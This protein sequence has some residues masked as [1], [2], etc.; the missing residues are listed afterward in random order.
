MKKLSVAL[1]AL[2]FVFASCS[3][4]STDSAAPNNNNNNNNNPETFPTTK[5]ALFLY[6]T[7]SECNP[8]GSIGIPNYNTII[9][10]LNYKDKVVPVS[11]HCN[12]PAPD[13]MYVTSTGGDLLQLIIVNNSYSAPTYLVPPNA[14]KS[15]VDGDAVSKIQSYI[16]TISSQPPT[17]VANVSATYAA[18]TG[19]WSVKTRTKFLADDSADFRVAVWITEDGVSWHQVAN[20]AVVNPFIHD[21]VLRG[22]FSSTFG[23][24]I[25]VGPVKNGDIIEK[26]ILGQKPGTQTVPNVWNINNL[27]AVVVLFKYVANAT[28]NTIILNAYKIKLPIQ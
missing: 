15:G 4:S 17:A 16:N 24:D 27:S 26:T 11:V 8:C 5:Q 3:K 25:K 22:A 7:G 10:N 2:A 12:A 18:S 21:Q 13:A 19:I 1:I 14:Q 6:F 23:D 9:T 28:P 20:G